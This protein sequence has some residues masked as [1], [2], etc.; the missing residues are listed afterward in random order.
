MLCC[1]PR[2]TEA[3]ELTGHSEQV[4]ILDDGN[5]MTGIFVEIL[6]VLQTDLNFTVRLVTPT[7]G[8]TYGIVDPAT[9]NWNG[10]IGQLARE[11]ADFSVNFFS[12]TMARSQVV[13]FTGDILKDSV[14]LFMRKPIGEA[15]CKRAG[16]FSC[17]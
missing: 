7:D 9:G 10:V 14:H 13:S 6:H 1:L 16:I 8:G 4:R 2:V 5:R 12:V 15:I 3:D 17:L 11:E